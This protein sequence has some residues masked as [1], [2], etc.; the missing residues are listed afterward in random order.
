ML[1]NQKEWTIRDLAAML[2]L[3]VATV[4]RALNDDD[5]VRPQ[6]KKRV[7]ELVERVGYRVNDHAK[8]LRNGQSGIIG[9]IVPRLDC[10]WMSAVVSGIE[11]ATRR[12]EYSLIV[13]QSNGIYETEVECA[14]MLFTKRVEGVVVSLSGEKTDLGHLRRFIRK[15]I[16]VV[17]LDPA[18]SDQGF[19][20]IVIDD[21]RAGYD[22]TRHL[23]SLG[24]RRILHLSG[25]SKGRTVTGGCDGYRQAYAEA[26]L[27]VREQYIMACGLSRQDGITAAE[28][29][30]RWPEKPDAIIA[31]SD[32]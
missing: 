23:L 32:H 28:M 2:N 12:Q 3:S 15:D 8:K 31:P 18:C 5:N 13:M 9:C 22:L 16:P 19:V 24:R 1:D 27:P 30:L 26:G 10:Q 7:S 11:S 4:S 17:L 21:A 6:T 29:V 25:Q 14:D 20:N